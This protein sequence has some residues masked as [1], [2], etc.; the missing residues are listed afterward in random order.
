[1][2]IFDSIR[3][4][5]KRNKD[6]QV[7]K[8]VT[9]V[10]IASSWDE[11]LAVFVKYT[12]ELRD[13]GAQNVVNDLLGTFK[14]DAYTST[15]IMER[16]QIIALCRKQGIRAV[17]QHPAKKLKEPTESLRGIARLFTADTAEEAME[18]VEN[19]IRLAR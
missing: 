6:P 2:G 13:S 5:F 1:M 15:L 9:Q 10:M 11:L 19:F 8:A 14:D 4:M 16:A 3:K 12:S 17:L 18:V 7:V